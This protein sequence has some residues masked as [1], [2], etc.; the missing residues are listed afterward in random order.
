MKTKLNI[1]PNPA[2]FTQSMQS[3]PCSNTAA[4]ADIIDNSLDANAARIDLMITKINNL[5]KIRIIDTGDGMDLTTLGEALKFGSD[6]YKDGLQLGRFG[7]GLSTAIHHLSKKATVITKKNNITNAAIWDSKYII[8]NN[9]NECD[10]GT[11]NREELKEF[12]KYIQNS[13]G[14]IIILEQC[15]GV[16]HKDVQIFC[17]NL[18]NE[19]SRK[20]R[21]KISSGII[22]S[23]NREI[24]L[25]IDPL[26]LSNPE[27]EIEHELNI[28]YN[29]SDIKIKIV[30]LPKNL[31]SSNISDK[32]SNLN[33]EYQGFYVMRNGREIATATDLG[34][35]TKKDELNRF[36]AQLD[37]NSQLDEFVGL[38]FTKNGVDLVE[39]LKK[40]LSNV[41][42]PILNE[43]EA[44]YVAHNTNNEKNYDYSEIEK[45]IQGCSNELDFN[46]SKN[47]KS[48]SNNS[49][50]EGEKN[51][52]E[53]KERKNETSENKMQEQEPSKNNNL[54]KI[55]IKSAAMDGNIMYNYTKN[56]GELIITL[57]TEHIFHKALI[58]N[59]KLLTSTIFS[60][61]AEILAEVKTITETESEQEQQTLFNAFNRLNFIKS[62]NME[63]LLKSIQK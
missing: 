10:I 38:N 58:E 25:A 2:K 56:T 55:K 43:L 16:K 14:T 4:I 26:H 11:A 39:D 22:I 1:N 27:V 47:K 62:G 12:N 50:D 23:V 61:F 8:E 17:K 63:I 57:N 48:S 44:K 45:L 20:F 34:I 5:F 29:N 35:Y 52:N 37:F 42:I 49:Q 19:I 36:R 40:V 24:C 15:S 6:T 18:K 59:K 31:K 41:I 13:T 33:S 60:I 21:D 54:L 51:S 7:M 46:L 9:K 28:P 32:V 53:P 30:S 3:I